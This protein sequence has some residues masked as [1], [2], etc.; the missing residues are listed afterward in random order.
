MLNDLL[1]VITFPK[2]IMKMDIQ[3]F[4]HKAFT[5]AEELFNKVDITHIFLE[6]AEMKHYYGSSSDKTMVLNMIKMLEKRG[7][8]PWTVKG[9]KLDLNQWDK[10]PGDM[11]W[12]TEPVTNS[13]GIAKSITSYLLC[14]LLFFLSCK[15]FRNLRKVKELKI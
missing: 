2:A 14:S 11:I 5:K 12:S 3:G 7:F 4:E 13:T 1:E 9:D 6:W 15:I 10:W 8:S